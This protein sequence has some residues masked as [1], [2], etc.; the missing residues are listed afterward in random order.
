MLSLK[1]AA[2]KIIDDDQ[3]YELINAEFCETSSLHNAALVELACRIRNGRI[4]NFKAIPKTLAIR[5]LTEFLDLTDVKAI[6]DSTHMR[7]VTDW[8]TLLIGCCFKDCLGTRVMLEWL[9]SRNIVTQNLHLDCTWDDIEAFVASADKWIGWETLNGISCKS[10]RGPSSIRYFSTGMSDTCLLA[11]AKKCYAL[12]ICHLDGPFI[13]DDGVE[14]LA[15][16]CRTLCE[17]KFDCCG[18][19]TDA[20]FFALA[21]HC[22]N[23]EKIEFIHCQIGDKSVVALVQNC[24]ALTSVNLCGCDNISSVAIDA[25]ANHCGTKLKNLDLSEIMHISSQALEP[26]ALKCQS[27]ESFTVG[28]YECQI[29]D[30]FVITMAQN[31]NSLK[32]FVVFNCDSKELT[33]SSVVAL[34]ENCPNIECIEMYLGKRVMRTTLAMLQ[35]RSELKF[36]LGQFRQEAFMGI[37]C[38][39]FTK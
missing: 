30:A 16:K 17:V 35:G 6:D 22:P 11:L 32:N 28:Y 31:C 13:S 8:S 36:C 9:M 24:P 14:I 37:I 7:D 12:F 33:D 3:L 23:L 29:T 10:V 38:V 26:L 21:Q 20:G 25:L 27:L 2:F 5:L 19:V 39:K 1:S 15:T 4:L 18:G 34:F